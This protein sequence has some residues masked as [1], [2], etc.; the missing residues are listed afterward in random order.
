M[1]NSTSNRAGK[2]LARSR[3]KPSAAGP[4]LGVLSKSI[5]AANDPIF[6]E[7]PPSPAPTTGDAGGVR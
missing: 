1:T 4:R 2:K 7:L 3:F 5:S 6:D